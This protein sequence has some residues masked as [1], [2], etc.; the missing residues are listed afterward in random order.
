MAILTKI[1]SNCLNSSDIQIFQYNNILFNPGGS[2]FFNG[3]CYTDTNVDSSLV[4]VFNVVS[5]GY[6][7]CSEC[8][9][10][11]MVGLYLSSC[12]SAITTTISVIP[13]LVPQIGNVLLFNNL[14]IQ[15]IE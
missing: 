4:A 10:Q 13:S 11:N 15:L 8:I 12:T 7:D 5:F 1:F 2:I 3:S 6:S 14:K 9:Q